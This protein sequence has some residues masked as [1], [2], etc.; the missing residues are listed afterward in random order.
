MIVDAQP[1]DRAPIDGEPRRVLVA[2][3]GQTFEVARF[4][5]L[6]S[7]LALATNSC[8]SGLGRSCDE[9]FCRPFDVT[10]NRNPNYPPDVAQG[11]TQSSRWPCC[12]D[13]SRASGFSTV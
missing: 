11:L 2:F 1:I 8:P 5:H 3:N 6:R 7:C 9:G 12:E 10:I 4:G 13:P